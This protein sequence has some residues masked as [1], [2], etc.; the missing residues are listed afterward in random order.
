LVRRHFAHRV[1]VERGALREKTVGE[2]MRQTLRS[3]S[4]PSLAE[5]V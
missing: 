4:F 2:G 1:A 3:I 5:R